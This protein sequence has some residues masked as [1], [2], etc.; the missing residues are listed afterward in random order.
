MFG[1][2]AADDGGALSD[3]L[4][5]VMADL[6][7]VKKLEAFAK[8]NA[9]MVGDPDLEEH[10]HAAY[11]LYNDYQKLFEKLIGGFLESKG[12]TAEKLYEEMRA[13]S[14]E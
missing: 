4:T 12:H 10:S 6:T 2:A 11:E 14:A 7:F 1:S 3:V 9:H 8:D 13:K 5:F